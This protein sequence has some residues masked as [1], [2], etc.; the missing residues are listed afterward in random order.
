MEKS[1]RELAGIYDGHDVYVVASGPSA[2]FIEP[3]FFDNKAAIGVNE[4]WLR[5]PNV[6]YLVRKEG[7][8]SKAAYMSEIPLVLSKHNCGVLEY[9][10]NTLDGPADYYIFEHVDNELDQ[11]DL[12]VIGTDE[13]IV[14][15]STITSAMHLAAYMGAANIILVGHDCGLIDGEHN[16]Q[17]YPVSIG[18]QSFYLDWLTKIE[19]QSI[20][21]RAALQEH[22][23]CRIYSLNPFLNLGMEG[24]VY[25][26]G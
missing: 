7:E 23:G 13:L 22:Y 14:S 6:D 11:V 2:G 12:S 9:A 18:G 20:Q 10:L 19:P 1:I 3:G 21:V 17:G 26:R 25:S 4:A 5:F 16:M 15:W 24:H 8:R